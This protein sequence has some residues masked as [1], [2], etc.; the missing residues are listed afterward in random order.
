MDEDLDGR[1]IWAEFEL[2]FKKCMK[3]ERDRNGLEPRALYNLVR[4]MMFDQS[5]CGEINAENTY[6]LLYVRW[7]VN[8]E[9]F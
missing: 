9:Y 1:V 4:F 3:D 5:R 7:K 6:E 2:M 8:D